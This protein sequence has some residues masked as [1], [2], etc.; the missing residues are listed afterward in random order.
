MRLMALITTSTIVAA[1][2]GLLLS[3]AP[4]ALSSREEA[5]KQ[6]ELEAAIKA[7]EELAKALEQ[8]RARRGQL[9]AGGQ[10]RRAQEIPQLEDERDRIVNGVATIEFPGVGA[11]V[12]GTSGPTATSWCT[13]TLIG[14]QTFLTANHCVADD[15]T[16]ANYQVYF[17]NLGFV[18]VE[19]ISPPHKEYAFP[20]ADLAVL[21]LAQPT[22]GLPVSGIN[23]AFVVPE[24]TP[25]T[26]IGFGR[27]GGLAQ[28]PGV[29]RRGTVRTA[30]CDRKEKS[31]LCWDFQAP[32]GLP[33][34]TSNTCN[35]DSGG[36]LFVREATRSAPRVLAG[37]TSGGVRRDCLAGDHS[38]DVDVRQFADWIAEQAGSDLGATQC[39]SRPLVGTERV[40]VLA[41]MGGLQVGEAQ[42]YRFAVPQG[43]RLLVVALNGTDTAETNLNLF[44]KRGAP[45]TASDNNCARNETGNYAVC[46]FTTP[47]S[48]DWFLRVDQ[49]GQSRA[50]FQVVATMYP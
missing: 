47:V 44:V 20:H 3:Q 39:G 36:P 23:R 21:R 13:G 12:T 43:V 16:P 33:G 19:R 25:G 6:A 5:A 40:K 37:V 14:C 22:E 49:Q 4:R 8:V 24:Q 2:G 7:E 30:K 29:K 15:R 18:A 17:Q 10:E 38:Y 41:G 11:L 32:V 1:S 31:L 35:V 46:S 45:A 28:D 50:E 27:T 42:D 34:E 9:Q 48:G 26:L